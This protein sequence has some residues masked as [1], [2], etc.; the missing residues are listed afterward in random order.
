MLIKSQLDSA[1]VGLLV[2]PRN[3]KTFNVRAY[4]STKEDNIV[5]KWKQTTTIAT[6]QIVSNPEDSFWWFQVYAPAIAKTGWVREDAGFIGSTQTGYGQKELHA[7]ALL[8]ETTYWNIRAAKQLHSI[9]A[10]LKEAKSKGKDVSVAQSKAIAIAQRIKAVDEKLRTDPSV[11]AFTRVS[12]FQQWSNQAVHDA[13][14]ALHDGANAYSPSMKGVGAVEVPILIIIA[15]VAVATIVA[16]IAVIKAFEPERA[17]AYMNATEA[18]DLDA[19]LAGLSKEQK[20]KVKAKVNDMRQDNYEDG[21][22]DAQKGTLAKT[23]QS[24]AM[25]AAV[26]IAAVMLLNKKKGV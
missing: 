8:A 13:G 26:G 10:R 1:R 24:A 25:V 12:S 9:T 17:N 4:V 21:K 2:S 16:C 11:Q 20:D 7:N 19:M 5:Y 6:G 14:Q 18:A 22:A 3:G 23:L 15:V